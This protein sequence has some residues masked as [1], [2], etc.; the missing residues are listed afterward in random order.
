MCTADRNLVL[1]YDQLDEE[2]R[3]LELSDSPISDESMH[4]LKQRR[5]SLK[6]TLYQILI[7]Q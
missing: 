7:A 6:D 4:G 2:I 1:T 3:S 5:A